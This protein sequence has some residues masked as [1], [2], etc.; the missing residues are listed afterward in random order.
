MTGLVDFLLARIDE[1]QA[2]VQELLA[3]TPPADESWRAGQLLDATLRRS[4]AECEAKRRLLDIA[5]AAN[6]EDLKTSPRDLSDKAWQRTGTIDGL[7]KALMCAALPYS[8]HPD[9]LEEWRP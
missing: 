9:Y 2:T 7:V 5:I 8:D 6:A 3:A 4:L 1:D